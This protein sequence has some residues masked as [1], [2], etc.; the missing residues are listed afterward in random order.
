MIAGKIKSG[1]RAGCQSTNSFYHRHAVQEANRGKRNETFCCGSILDLEYYLCACMSHSSLYFDFP[2][3]RANSKVK[4][5]NW[6][7]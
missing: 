4:I 7:V 1:D 2:L 6:G 5:I 3:K